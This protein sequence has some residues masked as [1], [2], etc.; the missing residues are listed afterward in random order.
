MRVRAS[1]SSGPAG[2][3]SAASNVEAAAESEETAHQ[4]LYH[5]MPV[6]A[7]SMIA[8]GRVCW[9]WALKCLLEAWK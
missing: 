6:N 8:E 4:L 9:L 7:S 2:W 1:L 5:R 3:D